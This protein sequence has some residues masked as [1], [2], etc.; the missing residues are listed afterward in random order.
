M[1]ERMATEVLLEEARASAASNADSNGTDAESKKP[2]KSQA[3][4]LIE[5]VTESGAEMF[6]TPSAD[7]FIS[8]SIAE[9]T[10]TWPIRSKAARRWMTERFYRATSK[11]PRAEA[12]QAALGVIEA[13]A[14]FTAK[15]QDVNLRTAWHNGALYYD[16]ADAAWRV[17]RIGRDGWQVVKSSPIY[18]RRYSH[19]AAQFEPTRDGELKD[20]WNFLNVNDP[21]DRRLLEAWLVSAFIPDIPRPVLVVHGEQGAAKSTGCKMLHSFIDPSITPC[22]RTRDGTE[23]V[24]AL[25]HR[26]AAVLD[27]VST[28]PE[29]LSDLL[30]CA[31][32]GDGFSKR[33]LFTDDDDVIYAYKRALLFNGIN[34]PIS[35]SDLLDRSLLV[36]FE[37]IADHRGEKELWQ[38]FDSQRPKILGAIFTR[39]SHA[40][41]NYDK[42]EPSRLPRMADFAKWA[43]AAT[44][45]ATQF[46]EDYAA[47][48]QR[49]TEQAVTESV[50]A[51]VLLDW[52]EGHPEKW[53]GQAEQLHPILKEH[54]TTMKI[55][56]KKFPATP[57]TLSKKLR[58]VRPNLASLG[59]TI[60]FSKSGRRLIS[61]TRKEAKS[62]V[63]TVRTVH[64]LGGKDGKD[65][66]IPHF[67][68][69]TKEETII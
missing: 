63:L 64:E 33:M 14:T 7:P 29:W 34:I 42:V 16:L 58:E 41:R 5:L 22:L 13:I 53:E 39:L 52:L 28:L 61:I 69:H 35:K 40:I 32:T 26:F 27:N 60:D 36:Q 9:H 30:C 21:R 55:S 67:S 20:I 49:Q 1:D 68:G 6:H 54:A 46:L 62:S 59:W 10:E 45:D 50:T 15:E 19:T 2:R 66:K 24:Q 18:F 23:L 12:M 44:G 56:E 11:A 51:T 47:N 25:A 57:A 31:V 3:D 43:I 65:G 17:V 4:I 48:V 8:F 37:E 38:L